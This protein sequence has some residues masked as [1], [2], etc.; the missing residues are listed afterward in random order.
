MPKNDNKESMNVNVSLIN[1][2]TKEGKKQ[3]VRMNFQARSNQK[4][5]LR[6]MREKEYPFLDSDVSANFDELLELKLIELL[7]M[8][9]PDEAGKVDPNYCKYHRLMSHPF[10]KSFVLKYRVML[11][12]R[13]KKIVLDDEKAGFNQIS[14]TFSSFDPIQICISEKHEEESLEQDKSQVDRDGHESWIHVTR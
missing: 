3:S 14:I 1:F 5:I 10:E 4:S 13:E 6:E 9:Q 2:T 8:K 11:L 7:E 12:V